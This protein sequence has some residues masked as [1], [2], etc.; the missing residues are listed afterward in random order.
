MTEPPA[1]QPATDQPPLLKLTGVTKDFSGTRALDGVDF[2]VR[3]G[4]IHALVG[5]NGAGKSTLMNIIGGVHAADAGQMT[6][7]GQP[8][9]PSSPHDSDRLGIRVIHQELT[10]VPQLTVAQNIML[11][12]EPRT[13]LGG[14]NRAALR[15]R[16]HAILADLGFELPL[17]G[18]VEDLGAGQQQLVEIAHAFA[19]DMRV[20][21]LD[22]PTATLSHADVARLFSV[23]RDLRARGLGLVY[24]SHRL[25]ELPQ[26]A[27]RVT[28]LRDGKVV[29]TC[30]VGEVSMAQVSR[31]M[32]GRD[33]EGA[34]PPRVAPQPTVLLRVTD[35]QLPC[36]LFG[37]SFEL[38]AGEVLGLA[39]LLG[40][41]RTELVRAIFGAEGVRPRVEVAGRA[42][43]VRSPRHARSLGL[44]LIP[45][46]RRGE[47]LVLARPVAE[48]L[49]LT[50]L[51]TLAPF[52]W[53][54]RRK[55]RAHAQA[56]IQRFSVRPADPEALAGTLSGG[57]QQKVVVAKW[58]TTQP[59]VFLFDEPSRGI[60]VGTKTELYAL[61][62]RLAAAGHGVV[63]VSSELPELIGLAH[64]ILVLHEGRLT[65]ELAG[66]GADEERLLALCA[67][68]A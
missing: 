35:L 58:V 7:A 62:S 68:E 57:N 65:A 32:L 16:A 31:L 18:R 5:E 20:L 11:G 39:G 63:V 36:R 52:G 50:V 29:T 28:V 22:E 25:A 61:I 34:F 67:G 3:A 24:I 53:I 26:I 14:V 2:E 55:L 8:V 49:A 46:D 44:A 10:L 47:G 40:A 17:E 1:P 60:D 15:D 56:A 23:L 19:R 6:V 27:D 13:A 37:I 41:G 45:E 59:R 21:I 66:E 38:R 48:N 64:R 42:I 33:L 9:H 30:P 51:G 12:Q 43:R 4:E 54:A